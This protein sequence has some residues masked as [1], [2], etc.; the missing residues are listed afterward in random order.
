MPLGG[1][2]RHPSLKSHLEAQVGRALR[3]TVP[4]PL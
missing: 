1:S 3:E 2:R 4:L